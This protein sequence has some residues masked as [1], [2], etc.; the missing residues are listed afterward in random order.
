VVINQ[1]PGPSAGPG[2]TPNPDPKMKAS[3]IS[4]CL[5]L[6]FTGNFPPG[7]RRAGEPADSARFARPTQIVPET[8]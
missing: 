1:S 5:A 7:L 4:S 8:R 2:F 3:G 6:I